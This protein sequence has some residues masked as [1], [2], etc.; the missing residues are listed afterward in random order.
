MALYRVKVTEKRC[1]YAWVEADSVEEAKDLA[2]QE[3]EFQFESLYDC[4][5]LESA[6]TVKLTN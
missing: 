5:V 2:L 1:D 6:R 4:K 3:V